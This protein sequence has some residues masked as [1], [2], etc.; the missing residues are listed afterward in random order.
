M[1]DR[2]SALSP[3]LV[4]AAVLV[5]LLSPYVGGADP[6]PTPGT[7]PSVAGPPVDLTGHWAAADLGSIDLLQDGSTLTGTSPE[8]VV[9]RGTITGSHATFT[10]W[11]GPSYKRSD[12][13]DRGQGTIGVSPDGRLI[14]VTWRTEKNGG[15]YN[16]TLT[17]IR[18]V[19]VG[20]GQDPALEPEGSD[21]VVEP[22]GQVPEDAWMGLVEGAWESIEAAIGAIAGADQTTL[23]TDQVSVATLAQYEGYPNLFQAA[24]HMLETTPAQETADYFSLL[25]ANLKQQYERY[26]QQAAQAQDASTAAESALRLAH[27]NVIGSQQDVLMFESRLKLARAEAASADKQV[28][29]ANVVLARAQAAA[30]DAQKSAETAQASWQSAVEGHL[31][32]ERRLAAAGPGATASLQ[33]ALDKAIAAEAQAS[34]SYLAA[35]DWLERVQAIVKDDLV[36]QKSLVFDAEELHKQAGYY[37]ADHQ[38]AVAAVPGAF[39]SWIEAQGDYLAKTTLAHSLT[40][41]ARL[42]YISYDQAYWAARSALQ[43]VKSQTSP[44]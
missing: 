39:A 38:K 33:A 27:E 24:M 22:E 37:E 31:A 12:K 32:A 1:R 15:K 7:S 29:D 9:I 13:E 41:S 44:P 23:A 6:S 20:G 26:D 16:G 18:V 10:F 11:N 19:P 42:T 25:A 28:A 21:P 30:A 43:K 36:A 8:G 34:T 2:L 3:S 4:L 40:E 5:L 14:T 35:T 17:A